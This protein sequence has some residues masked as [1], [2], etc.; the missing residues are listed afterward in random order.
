MTTHPSAMPLPLRF[1]LEAARCRAMARSVGDTGKR[2]NFTG[3]AEQYEVLAREAE[4]N[5]ARRH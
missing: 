5:Q 3:L 2:E 4:R 1:R